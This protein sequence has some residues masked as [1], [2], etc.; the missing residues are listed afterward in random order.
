[1]GQMR[2][3]PR[4]NQHGCPDHCRYRVPRRGGAAATGGGGACRRMAGWLRSLPSTRADDVL[5]PLQLYAPGFPDRQL[6]NDNFR[7]A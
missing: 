2:F 6:L 4:I 1:M 3:E 7:T 5:S